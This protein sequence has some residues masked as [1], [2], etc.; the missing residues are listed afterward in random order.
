MDIWPILLRASYEAASLL[1]P[2]LGHQPNSP[3]RRKEFKDRL[4][5]LESWPASLLEVS[6]CHVWSRIT[7]CS[8]DLTVLHAS[9]SQQDAGHK[10]ASSSSVSP[11]DC[12]GPGFCHVSPI[13]RV[14][15]GG[16]PYAGPAPAD[17]KAGNNGGQGFPCFPTPT[18]LC[19]LPSC[20]L[21]EEVT[22][23]WDSLAWPLFPQGPPP[24][25][26]VYIVEPA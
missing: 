8:P 11:T 16:T 21:P 9:F 22:L 1:G 4:L 5:G 26:P 25:E 7:L 24:L 19:S 3:L 15:C 23:P 20:W 13:T 2:A 6:T 12:P 18:G 14:Q 17:P 10:S